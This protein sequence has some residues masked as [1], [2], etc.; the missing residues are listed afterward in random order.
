MEELKRTQEKKGSGEKPSIPTVKPVVLK[1]V[2][3]LVNNPN[4]PT[5]T[6]SEGSSVA[7]SVESGFKKV[8]QKN[9]KVEQFVPSTVLPKT[10]ENQYPKSV[11][12]S[13]STLG[14]A[15]SVEKKPYKESNSGPPLV[16]AKKLV[17][18]PGIPTS[19]KEST[20]SGLNSHGLNKRPLVESSNHHPVKHNESTQLKKSDDAVQNELRDLYKRVAK[21]EETVTSLQSELLQLKTTHAEE[22]RCKCTQKNNEGSLV[23]I[24]S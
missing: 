5:N 9:P 18:E 13:G 6:Q 8:G 2:T 3:P 24:W 16:D 22:H 19:P 4:T 14:S 1:P 21:L 20:L 12:V 15:S 10:P 17:P 11:N 23:H 7:A